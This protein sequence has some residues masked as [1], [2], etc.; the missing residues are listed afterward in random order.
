M[1][2]PISKFEIQKLKF[3]SASDLMGFRLEMHA[4]VRSGCLKFMTFDKN[5][6]ER[7]KESLHFSDLLHK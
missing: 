1:L 2:F 4:V 5:E 6:R 3:A 7:P